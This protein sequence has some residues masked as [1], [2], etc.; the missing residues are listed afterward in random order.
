MRTLRLCLLS[1]LVICSSTKAFGQYLYYFTFR[2]VCSQVNSSGAISTTSISDKTLL[3]DISL[4]GG[5]TDLRSV[6]LVYHIGGNGLGDTVDIV[7][8]ATGKPLD[9]V[10]GLYF[11][12]SFGRQ[13]ITNT[14]GK[15]V[16]RLDYVY[17]KQND[18]SLGSAL[19]TK[20]TITDKKG[21]NH[22]VIQGQIQYVVESTASEPAKICSGTF[23][24]TKP[25]VPTQSP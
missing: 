20:S 5:V 18:H 12:E 24:A 25:L 16:R 11:G 19:I 2:G 10:F 1:A 3:R 15:V 13:A 6:A 17:T 21:T 8:S 23:T 22:V 4:A 7:N 14:N 9:T